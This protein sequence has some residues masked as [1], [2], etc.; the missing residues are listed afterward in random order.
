MGNYLATDKSLMGHTMRCTKYMGVEIIAESWSG[1]N[2]LLFSVHDLANSERL[3]IELWKYQP[4]QQ[5][6][7]NR[8][9][10]YLERSKDMPIV[11]SDQDWQWR[12]PY[13]GWAFPGPNFGHSLCS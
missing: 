2:T 10:I 13:S 3:Q 4:R 5:S 9:I 8:A 6:Y 11:A 7:P 12:A 1:T